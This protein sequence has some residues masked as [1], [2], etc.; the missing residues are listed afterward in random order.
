MGAD[1]GSDSEFIPGCDTVLV[2]DDCR[3]KLLG[4]LRFVSVWGSLRAGGERK[5]EGF[6]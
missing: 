1:H 6:D 5:K 3:G 2:G 4:G